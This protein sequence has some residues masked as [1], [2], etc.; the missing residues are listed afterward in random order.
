MAQVDN[1]DWLNLIPLGWVEIAHDMIEE[2]EAIYPEWEICDLKEKWGQ[3]R[4]YDNGVPSTLRDQIDE[5]IEK[6]EKL[7]AHT[8]NICGAPATK[9]SNGWILPFCDDCAERHPNLIFKD[10]NNGN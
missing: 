1:Y 4:C 3:L 6:Y 10:I 5:I 8:C 2:C 9:L 7:S